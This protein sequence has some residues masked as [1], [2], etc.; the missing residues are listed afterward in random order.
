MA[1]KTVRMTF[2][3]YDA[4]GTDA[5][6]PK[7]R[8]RKAGEKRTLNPEQEHEMIS[9]L[10][11]HDPAQFKLKG[12]MW[13]R[14]S[15]RELIKVKY[16]ITMPNRTVGEY[17]RRWGFTVQRPAKRA[18]NQKPEQAERWLEEEYPAIHRK[19]MVQ[20]IQELEE[21][22]SAFMDRILMSLT[23]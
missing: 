12:C 16:G 15:V 6:N 5:I 2:G 8:G 3:A 11:D 14:D 18:I 9:M 23:M 1:G 20:N 7:K 10:V 17:L 22:T 19:A 4:G 21:N 13:T